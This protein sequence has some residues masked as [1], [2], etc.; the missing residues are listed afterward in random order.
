MKPQEIRILERYFR[1]TK[2]HPEGSVEH[3][4]DCDFINI[5][6]CTCGLLSDLSLLSPDRCDEIYPSFY[7]ELNEYEKVR[8]G[9]KG[10]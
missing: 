2:V 4:G 5:R 1:K 9:L 3:H 6:I 7:L 10:E 8:A